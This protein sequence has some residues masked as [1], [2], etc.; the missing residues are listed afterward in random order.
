MQHKINNV[1][2]KRNHLSVTPPLPVVKADSGASKHYFRIQDVALLDNVKSASGPTVFLPNNEAL[3]A[4]K[5]GNL[6]I[7]QLSNN[8]KKA[9]IIPT[10]TN[11]SLLSLGQLCDDNCTIVLRKPDLQVYK[12]HKIILKGVQNHADGQWYIVWENISPTTHRANIIVQRQSL[13]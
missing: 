7:P 9:H 10:L 4:T 11:T 13:R 2:Q 3:Q 12:D 5:E 8:G 1:L 6:P